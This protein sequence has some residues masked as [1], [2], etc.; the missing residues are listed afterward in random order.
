MRLFTYS[1]LVPL[2][3]VC[4]CVAAHWSTYCNCCAMRLQG[5]YYFI[6]Y[7]YLDVVNPDT[8]IDH[9]ISYCGLGAQGACITVSL[10]HCPYCTFRT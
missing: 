10:Q 1:F 6:N 9:V 2:C 3:L 4:Y 5:A 8:V 7:L